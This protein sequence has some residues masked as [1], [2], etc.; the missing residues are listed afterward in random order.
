MT[1][2]KSSNCMPFHGA[3]ALFQRSGNFLVFYYRFVLIFLIFLYFMDVLLL[4]N[5]YLIASRTTFKKSANCM[6]FHGT[7]ALFQRSGN[8][9]VFLL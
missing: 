2:K 6:A 3:E 5:N 8:F 4:F 9:L 1:F 7:E